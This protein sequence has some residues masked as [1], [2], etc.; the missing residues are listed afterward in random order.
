M[1]SLHSSLL[2]SLTPAY[3]FNFT[4]IVQTMMYSLPSLL[5]V[6]NLALHS[7]FAHPSRVVG[8][9]AELLKGS[10]DTFI[11]TESP[12]A[13]ADLL[14]NIGSTGA[15]AS[16]AASGI[17]VASPDKTNPNCTFTLLRT[18]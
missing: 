7:I 15:C 9:D 5:L 18:I 6:S 17:V 11:T 10:V 16:G 3:I 14:C 13:L 4:I 12:I 2:S 1:D 8:R